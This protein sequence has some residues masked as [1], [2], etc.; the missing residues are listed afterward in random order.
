MPRRT[1]E[2]E[3]Q[4]IKA[5]W[6]PEN[7]LKGQGYALIA[8][9]D[10]AG[11]GPL[12]GPVFAAAVILPDGGLI[13]GINDSKKLTPKKREE[14]YEVI[15]KKALAWA[16]ASVDE[17]VIDEVNILNAT[18]IAMQRAVAELSVKPDYVLIDGNRAPELKIPC[19]TLVKGDS[20]SIS[21]AA[22]SIIAKVERDRYITRMAETY[23]E[24]AFEQHK[25]YGTKKHYE[26]ILKYGPSPIHRKTFL[27][28]LFAEEKGR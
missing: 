5:L 22:A 3:E 15:C 2:E 19:G 13:E 10:E 17:K 18:Y 1:K 27:K 7:S 21:I 24:Y 14:I 16:S 6:E 12:A 26:A 25:G 8:G 28:K 9:V 23:P 11:R 4:R 20:K